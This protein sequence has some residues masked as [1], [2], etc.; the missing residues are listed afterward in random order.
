MKRQSR[1]RASDP[2]P[3]VIAAAAVLLWLAMI[4]KAPE[5]RLPLWRFGVLLACCAVLTII[6]AKVLSFADPRDDL[7]AY[8]FLKAGTSAWFYAALMWLAVQPAINHWA[9]GGAAF[10]ASDAF[11]LVVFSTLALTGV[12]FAVRAREL[13]NSG[14]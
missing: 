5:L 11:T 1:R 3:A 4:A 12:A 8:C 14:L 7:T 10:W 2:V 9:R 13:A 6:W